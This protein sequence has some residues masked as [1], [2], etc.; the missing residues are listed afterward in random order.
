MFMLTLK[1]KAAL[2]VA[3]LVGVA[4][5]FGACTSLAL[6]YLPTQILMIILMVGV[7]GWAVYSLYDIFLTRL[8]VSDRIS[9]MNNNIK[10]L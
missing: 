4:M 8:E 7:L 2:Q 1:Q 9:K 5:V 10:E 3:K 6:T